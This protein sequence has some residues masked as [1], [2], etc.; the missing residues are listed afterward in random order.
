MG[1]SVMSIALMLPCDE[2]KPSRLTVVALSDAVLDSPPLCQVRDLS[3]VFVWVGTGTESTTGTACSSILRVCRRGPGMGIGES[4]M[5]LHYDGVWK[6][7]SQ[8]QLGDVE[9]HEA[10]C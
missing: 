8:I 3:P 2:L 10:L 9:K 7:P 6:R 1:V 4:I 5:I